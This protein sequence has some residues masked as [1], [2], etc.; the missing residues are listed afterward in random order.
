M[1]LQ[2]FED[3]APG[4]TFTLGPVHVSRDDVVGF[5]SEFDP[6]PMHL[7][8]EAG[9]ASMLGGLAGSGW[10][11][12]TLALRMLAEG[13]LAKADVRGLLNIGDLRW[14]SP[15]Y[16]DQDV[17]LA[18]E[19]GAQADVPGDAD[20]GAVRFQ[21]SLVAPDGRVMMTMDPAYAIARQSARQERS[22]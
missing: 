13:A 2:T 19:I 14:R 16:P 21:I 18:V 6:Q 17:R 5:A 3:F 20:V 11:M 10:H 22:A 1:I 15:F 7:D 8:E 9:R 4:M 12:T